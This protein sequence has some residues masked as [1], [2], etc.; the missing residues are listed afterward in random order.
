MS[1]DNVIIEMD[2]KPCPYCGST[3]IMWYLEDGYFTLECYNCDC[4][5]TG[6]QL[7]VKGRTEETAV[8]AAI[9]TWNKRA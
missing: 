5:A 3:D 4:R 9:E 7:R 8:R 1:A 6:P 2:V